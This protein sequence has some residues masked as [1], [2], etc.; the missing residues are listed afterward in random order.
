M[1]STFHFNKSCRLPR[2]R[3][4]PLPFPF[5]SFPFLLTN[6]LETG[7]WK[8]TNI[9][10]SISS[11]HQPD[12]L[13]QRERERARESHNSPL[14]PQRNNGPIIPLLIRLLLDLGAEANGAHDAIAKLLIQHRLVRVA[15]VLH[16]LVEAVDQRLDGG[17]GPGAAAVR[18]AEQLLREHGFGDGEERGE[19]R[20]VGGRGRGLPV[21]ERGDGDFG[22]VEGAGDGLEGEVLGGFGI[23][24]S[25]GREGEAV[26]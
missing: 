1:G 17:H 12:L 6:Y 11:N 16:D 24:E 5:L 22:P 4:L 3:I 25:F 7:K 2:L 15:V 23:E 9:I 26:D 14:P 13:D 8:P 19:R 20:D 10:I 18:E 21:E